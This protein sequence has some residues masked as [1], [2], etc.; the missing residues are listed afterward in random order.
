MEEIK[1]ITRLELIKKKEQEGENRKEITLHKKVTPEWSSSST[2]SKQKSFILLFNFLL[3]YSNNNI[4]DVKFNNYVFCII[5]HASQSQ[6]SLLSIF[7]T[8]LLLVSFLL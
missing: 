8:L 5:Q 3:M 2:N 1:E 4:I 6:S 7:P